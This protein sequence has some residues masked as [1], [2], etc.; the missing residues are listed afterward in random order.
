MGCKSDDEATVAIGK[1]IAKRLKKMSKAG[2]LIINPNSGA[3]TLSKTFRY[4]PGALA[5]EKSG[6]QMLPVGGKLAKLGAVEE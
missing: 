3:S 5:L 2:V 6:V 1:E 4:T